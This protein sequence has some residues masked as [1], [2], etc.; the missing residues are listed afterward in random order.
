MKK[1][2]RTPGGRGGVFPNKTERYQGLVS[3]QGA[4][5]FESARERLAKLAGRPSA[6]VSDG[7][8]I[9]FLSIGEAE[10]IRQIEKN[11]TA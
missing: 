1:K 6:E 2:P 5:C 3:A 8:T 7:D 10:S 9:Q 4:A 11:R